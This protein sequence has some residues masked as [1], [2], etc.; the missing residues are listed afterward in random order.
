MPT[1]LFQ[2]YIT[3]DRNYY[4]IFIVSLLLSSPLFMRGFYSAHDINVHVFR[5]IGTVVALHEMQFPPFIA[6]NLAGG[7][8]YA[9]NIFYPPLSAYIPAIF[10]IILPT[11]I[12]ALKLFIFLTTFLSGIFMFRFAKDYFKSTN[13]ALLASILYL[14]APYRL[15]DIYIRGALGEVLAFVFIPILFHGLYDLL[16][17]DK[18]KSYY[19]TIGATGLILS[20]NISALICFI[21]AIFYLLFNIKKV[22]NAKVFKMIVVNG[23]F[24][25]GITLFFI[26][27]LL[28]QKIFGNYVVFIPDRM[29]SI[30]QLTDHSVYLHQLLFGEF[31]WGGSLG[32]S[33]VKDELTFT[34]GL[35]IVLPLL[36]T[37][38]IYSKINNKNKYF[39]ILVIGIFATFATTVFFPW[40]IMPEFFSF[41]QFPWRLLMI[42]VF[43]F[44]VI[45]AQNMNL[46]FNKL[47]TKN[48]FILMIIIFIYIS[49]LINLTRNNPNISD[50]DFNNTKIT[51][52]N[53]QVSSDRAFNEYLPVNAFKNPEY[54]INRNNKVKVLSGDIEIN[55]E[56]NDMGKYTIRVDSSG[57]S[58]IELPSLFYVGWNAKI[59]NGS[60]NIKINTFETENGF[61]GLEIP[62][63]FKGTINVQFSGTKYTK[64]AYLIS[65]ISILLFII[66][67][68]KSKRVKQE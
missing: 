35:Q 58:Q 20:H 66:Y 14:T 18:K 67:I 24:I 27:P 39:S 31:K 68:W 10:K 11:Y 49:P 48:I 19:I 43:F 56:K 36:I 2:K 33:D 30:K 54:V 17:E 40:D 9:W 16:Y 7:F 34:L 21:I 1:R 64:I 42:S 53:F 32:L 4:F 52:E 61:V 29:G 6:P 38:V 44:S 15:V 50:I 51:Q 55:T 57:S 3:F 28:E 41:I 65:L 26:V 23:L 5:I 25:I 47:D 62:D 59:I 45:A 22:L 63:Q 8:G 46:F 12:G 60:E 13:G 37:P